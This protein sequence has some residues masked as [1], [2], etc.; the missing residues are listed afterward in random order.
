MLF[1][2]ISGRPYFWA[3]DF[4]ISLA[5][6][7]LFYSQGQ[8]RKQS[9]VDGF[10]MLKGNSSSLNDRYASIISAET[11]DESSNFQQYLV[12]QIRT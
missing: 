12:K 2:A 9:E 10:T 8:V 1:F 5:F 3:V 6:I 4:L 7:Y 11:Y